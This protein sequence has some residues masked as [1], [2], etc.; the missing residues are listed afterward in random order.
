MNNDMQ[1][2]IVQNKIVLDWLEFLTAK[3]YVAKSTYG[4]FV[5]TTGGADYMATRLHDQL[6]G[7]NQ[8]RDPQLTTP[9]TYCETI[10][11]VIDVET[12]KVFGG[13]KE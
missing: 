13:F 7:Y 8:T 5:W 1:A 11:A 3:G 10:G 12:A 6:L 2:R 9:V 4:I